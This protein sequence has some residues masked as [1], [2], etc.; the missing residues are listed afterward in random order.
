MFSAKFL[1]LFIFFFLGGGGGGGG[2]GGPLLNGV[3]NHEHP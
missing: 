1:F 3:T 2:G